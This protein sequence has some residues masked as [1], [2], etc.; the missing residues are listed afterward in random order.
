M[1]VKEKMISS[2]EIQIM[3]TAARGRIQHKHAVLRMPKDAA[4]CHV[5]CPSQLQSTE[6]WPECSFELGRM[7][8][9]VPKTQVEVMHQCNANA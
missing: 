1:N 7:R 2:L 4:I 3:P 5:N 8:I 9:N 6:T